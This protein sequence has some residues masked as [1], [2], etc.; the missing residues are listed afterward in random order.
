M[1][2]ERRMDAEERYEAGPRAQGY[3]FTIAVPA[4]VLAAELGVEHLA[5][6]R[7]GVVLA[8]EDDAHYDEDG[9]GTGEVDGCHYCE[10]CILARFESIMAGARAYARGHCRVQD[11]LPAAWPED[12][13]TREYR[14]FVRE[15]ASNDWGLI[16]PRPRHSHGLRDQIYHDAIRER[17]DALIEEAIERRSDDRYDDEED[18]SDR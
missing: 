3:A 15:G 7:C 10:A 8:H 16:L 13:E 18:E 2:S 1:R 12:Y 17:I 9:N 14:R 11:P 4:G 6:A 5:C